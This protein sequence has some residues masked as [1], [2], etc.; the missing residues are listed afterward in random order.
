MNNVATVFR[1]TDI[2]NNRRHKRAQSATERLTRKD[3]ESGSGRAVFPK[4]GPS[5]ISS[6]R[7]VGQAAEAPDAQRKTLI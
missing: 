3:H 5:T 4:G 2:D 6:N 1:V 7:G